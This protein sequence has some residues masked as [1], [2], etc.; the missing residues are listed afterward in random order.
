M[1]FQT[2]T[3][4]WIGILQQQPAQRLGLWHQSHWHPHW[5]PWHACP[6]ASGWLSSPISTTLDQADHQQ[7]WF[8]CKDSAQEDSSP[9]SSHS[10]PGSWWRTSWWFVMA[11][12]FSYW[13]T[14]FLGK[15]YMPRYSLCC[16]SVCMI[17][18]WPQNLACTSSQDPGLLSDGDSRQGYHT[19][20][21]WPLI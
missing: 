3:D 1:W 4:W 12:S 19:G 9:H 11:L 16:S 7:Y 21:M 15:G 13:E 18:G 20:P 8:Q 10:A 6:T 2:K 14:K 5:V 17:H